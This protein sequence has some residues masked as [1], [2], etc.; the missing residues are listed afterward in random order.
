M[1]QTRAT[2][3]NPSK[4][5]PRKGHPGGHGTATLKQRPNS[6]CHFVVG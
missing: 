3:S 2:P 5:S 1:I 4:L 6:I